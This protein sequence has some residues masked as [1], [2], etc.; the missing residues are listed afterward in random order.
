MVEGRFIF[1]TSGY[2]SAEAERLIKLMRRLGGSVRGQPAN[3]LLEG[4]QPRIS[5]S[6]CRCLVPKAARA[7]VFFIFEPGDVFRG[8]AEAL[9]A[10]FEYGR[11]GDL[12]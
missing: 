6:A 10:R 7:V 4:T 9:Q 12:M 8:I 2:G 3:D 5:L 11:I 1:Q